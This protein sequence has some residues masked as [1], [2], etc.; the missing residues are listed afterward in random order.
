MS[1]MS[2]IPGS[3]AWAVLVLAVCQAAAVSIP[4]TLFGGQPNSSD[5]DLLISPAGYAFAIWAVI[6]VLTIVVGAMFVKYRA[7]GT[8]SARRL[9]I[10]IAVACAA[11]ALWLVV[12]AANWTWVTSVLLTVMAVVL[13][14]AARI[15]AGPADEQ[16]GPVNTM[17]RVTVGIYASWATAAVFLNWASDFGK[18]VADPSVLGWQL[19]FLIGAVVLGVAVTVGYGAVLPAYPVVLIWAFAAIIVN[20]WSASTVVVVLCITAIVLVIVGYL[21]SVRRR[22][23]SPDTAAA[24]GSVAADG[25]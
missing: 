5:V 23:Q 22:G 16:A 3:L 4:L 12:S 18:T 19:I 25:R 17:V 6:Y 11:A 1:V 8:G 13:L 14:D 24:L 15:A 7:T 20:A 9:A 2:R 10:D 21:M